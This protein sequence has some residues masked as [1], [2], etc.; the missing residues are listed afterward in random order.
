MTAPVSYWQ[1]AMSGN[2]LTLN[3]VHIKKMR[4]DRLTELSDR[5]PPRTVDQSELALTTVGLAFGVALQ[6]GFSSFGGAARVDVGRIALKLKLDLV[7]ADV[8][9]SGLMDCG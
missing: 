7:V 1:C 9:A 4:G 2:G 6:D 5:L 8:N 3:N